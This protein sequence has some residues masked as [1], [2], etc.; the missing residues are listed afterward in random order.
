MGP[1]MKTRVAA[2]LLDGELE[3]QLGAERRL[4]EQERDGLAVE[5]VRIVA[6]ATL[7]FGGEI[8]QVEQ[9]VVGEVEVAEQVRGGGFEDL[10]GA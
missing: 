7:D 2:E 4:F 9:F 8:E 10:V 3:R 6:R 5:R 1:S